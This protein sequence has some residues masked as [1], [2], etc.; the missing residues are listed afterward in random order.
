MDFYLSEEQRLW[1]KVVHDFVAK[2]I[3]PLA[4]EINEKEEI[5][6]S[7]IQKMGPM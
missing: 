2:E 7:V 6:R 4:G 3:K 5:P 1:R